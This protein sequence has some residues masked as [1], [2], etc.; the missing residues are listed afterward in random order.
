MDVRPDLFLLQ[1]RYTTD[2]LVV[3]MH[4][5]EEAAYRRA[6]EILEDCGEHSIAC[7]DALDDMYSFASHPTADHF[8]CVFVLKFSEGHGAPELIRSYDE[9]AA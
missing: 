9:V 2:D 1:V 3:G 8:S 5:T 6:E 4:D 7:W